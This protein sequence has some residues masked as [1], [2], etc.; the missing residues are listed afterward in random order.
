LRPSNCC[1]SAKTISVFASVLAEPSFGAYVCSATRPALSRQ[2][3]QAST[4]IEFTELLP[5]KTS[6]L[7][8]AYMLAPI[9]AC[10]MPQALNLFW[11]STIPTEPRGYGLK[12]YAIA[13]PVYS[14]I[15]DEVHAWVIAGLR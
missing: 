12:Q 6:M 9:L 8:S 1:I 3:I 14:A 11:L 13:R 10:H 15:Q 5:P 2:V 7:Q 4:G